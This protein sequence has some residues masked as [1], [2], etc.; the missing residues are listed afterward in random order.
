MPRGGFRPGAGAKR[1]QK[2]IDKEELR[3]TVRA[4][5][6]AKIGP[7]VEAQLA[8]AGGLKYLVT[9]DR[10]NGKFLRVGAAR[11]NSDTEETIEVWE[12]DPCVQAFTDLLNR[13]LD[14]PK[15]QEIEIV[16]TDEA[17]K[18]AAL[19]AGRRR[20]AAARAERDGHPAPSSAPGPDAP[21]VH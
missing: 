13:A 1:G 18:I 7:L 21:G 5:V 3:E 15:E 14:R 8:N 19:M 17:A 10:K 11:A 20:A 4:M 2:R 6:A 9:R 12:K 16:V